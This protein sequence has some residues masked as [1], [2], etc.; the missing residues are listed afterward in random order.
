MPD[1]PQNEKYVRRTPHQ[2][3]DATQASRM[4]EQEELARKLPAN[5]EPAQEWGER[6]TTGKTIAQGGGPKDQR[7]S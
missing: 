2:A 6:L 3:D 7:G 1:E 5:T 4:K